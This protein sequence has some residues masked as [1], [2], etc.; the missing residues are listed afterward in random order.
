MSDWL[1]HSRIAHTNTDN[2]R[3]L[4]VLERIVKHENIL[5]IML[6]QQ[7]VGG[8]VACLLDS[9]RAGATD[10]LRQHTAPSISILNVMLDSLH[11]AIEPLRWMR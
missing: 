11:K 6:P 9:C 3:T 1:R 5:V 8:Q 7:V 4:Y 2:P 10:V